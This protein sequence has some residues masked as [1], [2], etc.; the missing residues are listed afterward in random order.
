M[1][2]AKLAKMEKM[3]KEKMMLQGA[4]SVPND[5]TLVRAAHSQAMA[6][7]K[8]GAEATMQY[9]NSDFTDIRNREKLDAL[10]MILAKKRKK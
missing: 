8:E 5:N 7:D 2:K 3:L 9:E 1:N 4:S 6:G 10:K